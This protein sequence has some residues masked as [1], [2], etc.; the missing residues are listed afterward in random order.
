MVSTGELR[1]SLIILPANS[2]SLCLYSDSR[3]QGL[4]DTSC[5]PKDRGKQLEGRK[6]EERI[7][8]RDEF[9][10]RLI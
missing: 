6:E 8:R 9:F 7:E 5:I 3:A 10:L 1:S 2:V 4:G